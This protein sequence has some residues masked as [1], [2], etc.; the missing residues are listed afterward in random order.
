MRAKRVAWINIGALLWSKYL[1]KN[2]A[3]TKYTRNNL[4]MQYPE[5]FDAKWL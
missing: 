3:Y 4:N 5:D 2:T 1:D